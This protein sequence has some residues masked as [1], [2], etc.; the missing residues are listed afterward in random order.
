MRKQIYRI[1]SLTIINII[2]FYLAYY[3]FFNSK[4]FKNINANLIFSL[5]ALNFGIFSSVSLKNKASVKILFV[6]L[7]WIIGFGIFSIDLK[8]TKGIT[9]FYIPIYIFLNSI[10]GTYL[11][12]RIFNLM[13]S[14]KIRFKI[15]D[16]ILISTIP[17][18]T[19]ILYY[20]IYS[21]TFYDLSLNAFLG[22]FLSLNLW[23]CIMIILIDKRQ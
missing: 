10:I 18:T 2:I 9:E 12:F 6:L 3:F 17:T 5:F 20:L 1:L 23:Q 14:E 13:N 11:I 15:K 21:Q 22:E 7:C 8:L 4:V 19:T 16:Y